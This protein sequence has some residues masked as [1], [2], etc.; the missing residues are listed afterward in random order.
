ML[1]RRHVKPCP[2]LLTYLIGTKAN[3]PTAWEYLGKE[4]EKFVAAMALDVAVDAIISKITEGAMQATQILIDIGS[5]A[6]K[7]LSAML[8][9]EREVP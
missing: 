5:G 7:Q 4:F 8:G 9:W 2:L 6:V 3:L 1:S